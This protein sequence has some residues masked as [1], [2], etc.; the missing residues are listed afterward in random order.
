MEGVLERQLKVQH[1]EPYFVQ[2]GSKA[3]WDCLWGREPCAPI[4]VPQRLN[5]HREQAQ[6]LGEN[7][8]H[9]LFNCWAYYFTLCKGSFWVAFKEES[10][11]GEN[12]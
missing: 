10:Y 9:W 5:G 2:K 12:A 3:V 11:A 8:G 4:G 7:L 1:K 6:A